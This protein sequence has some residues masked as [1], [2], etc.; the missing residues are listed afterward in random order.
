MNSQYDSRDN[1]KWKPQSDLSISTGPIPSQVANRAAATVHDYTSGE[2]RPHHKFYYS[3]GSMVFQVGC[4]FG[5]ITHQ[6]SYFI[7]SQSV[8]ILGGKCD[9]QSVRTSTR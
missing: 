5:L 2:P 9:L 3:D 7:C 1:L 8:R 4:H 6:N